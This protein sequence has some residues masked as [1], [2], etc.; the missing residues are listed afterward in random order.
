MSSEHGSPL[1]YNRRAELELPTTILP[2]LAE[3]I[4]IFCKE[5][6]VS[7]EMIVNK[8][9]C[10]GVEILCSEFDTENSHY[11]ETQDTE[12][13]EV[14]KVSF[15]PLKL[16]NLHLWKIGRV[17]IYITP[18]QQGLFVGKKRHI[19]KIVGEETDVFT[20]VANKYKT[21]TD[22][23]VHHMFEQSFSVIKDVFDN[24]KILYRVRNTDRELVDLFND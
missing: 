8:V 21:T 5:R 4:E 19:S 23:V 11:L 10:M 24:K 12:T 20:D 22:N 18:K 14:T 7:Q 2:T 9:R 13:L 1:W 3:E 6:N 17:T 16:H 15:D